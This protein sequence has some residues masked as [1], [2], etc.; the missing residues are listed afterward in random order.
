MR[1]ILSK[2]TYESFYAVWKVISL[3]ADLIYKF[4]CFL[5][6]WISDHEL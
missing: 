3:V 5:D 6:N 1:L 2:V 4:V